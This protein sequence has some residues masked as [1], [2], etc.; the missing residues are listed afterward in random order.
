MYYTL[1]ICIMGF[2][3]LFGKPKGRTPEEQGEFEKKRDA[4]I[5]AIG[6]LGAA[7]AGGMAYSEAHDAH[8]AEAPVAYTAEAP[9]TASGPVSIERDAAGKAVGATINVAAEQ[10]E[11]KH[12]DIDNHQV[13]V[14]TPER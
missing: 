9:A 8:A 11:L 12:L 1:T 2:E 3:S 7:V 10:P 14:P 5:A 6:A 13:S 4:G